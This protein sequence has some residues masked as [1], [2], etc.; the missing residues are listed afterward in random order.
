MFPTIIY[1]SPFPH[2]D[3]GCPDCVREQQALVFN[4]KSIKS[5]TTLNPLAKEFVP[6]LGRAARTSAH[7]HGESSHDE[8]PVIA[9]IEA[10]PPLP[11]VRACKK[12]S[13]GDQAPDSSDKICRRQTTQPDKADNKPLRKSNE[14]PPPPLTPTQVP[15]EPTPPGQ[16][17][18]Q[19][20]AAINQPQM[21]ATTSEPPLLQTAAPK[22]DPSSGSPSVL[23]RPMETIAEIVATKEKAKVPASAAAKKSVPTNEEVASTPPA[24]NKKKPDKSAGVKTAPV[25]KG[26]PSTHEKRATVTSLPETQSP[27]AAPPSTTEK[28]VTASSLP[29]AGTPKA[30]SP[31]TPAK[32]ATEPSLPEA[33][34]P[35]AGS[36]STPAKKAKVSSLPEA[37]SPK[38]GSPST[39]TKKATVSS[40]PE[41]GSPKAG[42]PSTPAKK[43]TV[44]SLPEASS[45]KAG[46]PSTPAKKATVSSLAEANPP[47]AGSSSTPEKEAAVTPCP[48][49]RSPKAVP[50]STTEKRATPT[51]VPETRSPRAAPQT[52]AEKTSTGMPLPDTGPPKAV[53]PSTTEKKATVAPLAETRS[54]KAATAD[55][56][57]LPA[58]EA[59]KEPA[60]VGPVQT[61]ATPAEPIVEQP[62]LKVLTAENNSKTDTE[63]PATKKVTMASILARA[64]ATAAID[65]QNTRR[66]PPKPPEARAK[67]SGPGIGELPEVNEAFSN[68]KR[69]PAKSEEQ[70][71][72]LLKAGCSSDKLTNTLTEGLARSVMRQG[73]HRC[74]E[75]EDILRELQR[76]F[77]PKTSYKYRV[78]VNLTLTHALINLGK[79]LQSQSLLLDTMKLVNP[80]RIKLDEQTALVTPCGHQRLDQAMVLS[81]LGKG[82][83]SQA[84]TMLLSIMASLRPVQQHT[85]PEKELMHTLCGDDEL[86]VLMCRILEKE[87][88]FDEAQTMLLAIMDKYPAKQQRLPS[89]PAFP[90]PCNN[91]TLNMN[92]FRLLTEIGRDYQAR[93]FLLQT[94][95]IAEPARQTLGEDQAQLTPCG[96]DKLNMALVKQLQ[97][98]GN[99]SAAIQLLT[100]V[101]HTP[102]R[103]EA[104]TAITPCSSSDLNFTMLKLL[105]EEFRLAEAETF[106]LQIMNMYR[107]KNQRNLP[108]FH[109][110]TTPCG[111]NFWDLAMVRLLRDRKKL[112]QAEAM[113][114]RLMAQHRPENQRIGPPVTPCGNDRLDLQMASLL[115]QRHKYH[116]A[117]SLLLA[118]MCTYRPHVQLDLSR[119][120]ALVTTCGSNDVDLAMVHL[121]EEQGNYDTAISLMLSSMTTHRPKRQRGQ[122]SRDQAMQTPCL[123]HTHNTTMLRLLSKAGK[124]EA[125][126]QFLQGIMALNRPNHQ[127]DLSPEE[128]LTTPCGLG[129]VDRMAVTTLLETNDQE[130][131]I[132]LML[133]MMKPHRPHQQQNLSHKKAM[134]TPCLLQSLNQMLFTVLLYHA[135]THTAARQLMLAMMRSYPLNPQKTIPEDQLRFTPC[136]NFTM[137][138]SMIMLLS[139][140]GDT[141][142]AKKLLLATMN[143]YRPGE[144]REL[145]EHLAQITPCQ[146][147]ELNLSMV[148]ILASEQQH[149][150]ARIM[151]LAMMKIDPK[152][153]TTATANGP[154]G[155]PVLDAAMLRILHTIG[156]ED[157]HNELIKACLEYYPED[158]VFLMH[159]L[160]NLCRQYKWADFDQQVGTMPPSPQRDL[161]V[162]I[163]YYNEALQC[164][165]NADQTRGREL[166]AKAYQIVDRA[167]QKSPQNASLLSHKAHCAR[168]LGQR[169]YQALYDRS[170]MLDPDMERIEKDDYWR[171]DENKV[172]ELLGV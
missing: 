71:R 131:S 162:F 119:E 85:L 93:L 158:P 98:E 52:T 33:S 10:F 161:S 171:N 24:G 89:N 145:P 8:A 135:R 96:N 129:D 154:C 61:G 153:P 57:R 107:P 72:T 95:A 144:E 134:I 40:L 42:S 41:A 122:I 172:I 81:N 44:S 106:L 111:S 20:A 168:I 169:E 36:P 167:L 16:K 12:E 116:E 159:H 100:A 80:E 9:D 102:G 92:M 115:C 127:A 69:D 79:Y 133:A 51:P 3:P 117:E 112:P 137:N 126:R 152:V 140:Q 97:K 49:T 142:G 114:H 6:G 110:I 39:Q 60:P 130:K 2:F 141:L 151:L 164:Y 148:R 147:Y 4:Q 108:G 86:D 84:R 75:A 54:P 155:N 136:S 166:C 31:S 19:V 113:M 14:K 70:F 132:N 34:S 35:K 121:L 118:L 146:Q 101:M 157:Q 87:R 105:E 25:S 124:M 62:P 73:T 56:S 99:R 15:I 11:S 77:T 7:H 91:R 94:M 150:E 65:S 30:G 163:R 128:A 138:M 120:E 103:D 90:L 46:L 143:L 58:P 32:K 22:P 170:R 50:P 38:A 1:S 21:K 78:T 66:M 125:C 26:T 165:L 18:R 27:K 82:Y 83:C 45:P 109:A 29:E 23:T 88:R 68:I 59:P 43:A 63:N 123:R 64:V 37:S 74:H 13:G 67:I 139:K 104:T 160:I 156:P 47:K 48:E 28:S 76:K 149:K 55:T 53:T 5:T 17:T